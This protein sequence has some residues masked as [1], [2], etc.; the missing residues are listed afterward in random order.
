MMKQRDPQS[1]SSSALDIAVFVR[2]MPSEGQLKSSFLSV[3]EQADTLSVTNPAHRSAESKETFSFDRVF[4]PDCSQE[5]VYSELEPGIVDSLFAGKS[6][7]VFSFGQ[8]GIYLE[9]AN[10]SGCRI[11]EDVF[12]IRREESLQRICRSRPP[13]Q[14]RPARHHAPCL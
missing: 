10:M 2:I 14:G 5:D 3:S 6:V 13:Q 11:R 4:A 1:P 9:S 8:E 7:G 12:A